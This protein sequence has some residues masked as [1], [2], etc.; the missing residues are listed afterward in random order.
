MGVSLACSRKKCS[1]SQR[2]GGAVIAVLGLETGDSS[3]WYRRSPRQDTVP[4]V[5]EIWTGASLSFLE[6]LA[7]TPSPCLA[8]STSLPGSQPCPGDHPVPPSGSRQKNESSA[9]TVQPGAP[10]H[11]PPLHAVVTS[12]PQQPPGNHPPSLPQ[13]KLPLQSHPRLPQPP[14]NFLFLQHTLHIH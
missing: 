13:K 14:S 10:V 11:N 5:V 4:P 3:T 12:H 9:P 8:S 2:R 1:P 6:G 7:N